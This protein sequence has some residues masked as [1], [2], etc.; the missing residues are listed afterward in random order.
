MRKNILSLSVKNLR[1]LLRFVKNF[2]ISIYNNFSE[3]K[4]FSKTNNLNL[5]VIS[6]GGVA[7]TTLIRYLKLYRIVN[8]END[9][10]GYKHLSKFPKAESEDLKIIYIYGSF[11]KIYNSLKR[12]NIFQ[13][14]MVKLGC[15]LCYIFWGTIEKFFFRLCIKKQINSF[16]NRKNV[17]L[18][19]FDNIWESKEDLKNFLEIDNYDFIK[20]FPKKK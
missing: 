9:R 16:K 19:H 2:F 8:D 7:T 18:L 14:Q 13:T 17:Y 12:R 5:L 20:N 11:Q 15:P 10:D 1:F 6:T 4:N 3:P